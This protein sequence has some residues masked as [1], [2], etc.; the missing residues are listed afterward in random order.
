MVIPI[1][2]L[3]HSGDGTNRTS[4]WVNHVISFQITLVTDFTGQRISHPNP[5]R[6]LP[7]SY[8]I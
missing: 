6:E 2:G 3:I 1:T 7:L 8:P 5:Q 4:Q